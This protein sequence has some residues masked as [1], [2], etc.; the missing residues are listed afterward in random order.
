MKYKLGKLFRINE[1]LYQKGI[2]MV[3]KGKKEIL[4]LAKFFLE[5]SN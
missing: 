4:N 3:K 1:L 2:S 5:Q